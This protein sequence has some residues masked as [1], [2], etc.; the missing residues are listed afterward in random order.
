MC[1]VCAITLPKQY[2]CQTMAD[3]AAH[4]THS[5][6][7]KLTQLQL[8]CIFSL[9]KKFEMKMSYGNDLAYVKVE[10]ENQNWPLNLQCSNE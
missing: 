6:K 10:G 9:S 1:S 4:Q 5:S 8:K 7:K 3:V 2:I